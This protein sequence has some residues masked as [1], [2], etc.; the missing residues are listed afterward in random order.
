MVDHEIAHVYG[1]KANE[2][3]TALEEAGIEVLDRSAQKELGLYHENNGALL[4]RAPE[5]AWLAYPWWENPKEAPDFASHVDIHNKPG[6]DPCELFFGWP[7][8]AVSQNTEKIK[9]THGKEGYT[10]FAST[11]NFEAK[12]LIELAEQVKQ[13]LSA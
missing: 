9:G 10:A 13:W 3:K 2:A 7:P 5:E 8:G 1:A 4:L 11:C 12:S 6:Y